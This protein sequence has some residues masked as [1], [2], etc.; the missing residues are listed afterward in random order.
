MGRVFVRVLILCLIF[1]GA[2]L[3]VMVP[4]GGMAF[5]L[6]GDPGQPGVS[7]PSALVPIIL[8]GVV[9]YFVIIGFSL[10]LG[11]MIP[12]AA[13]GHVVSVREALTL[14]KGHAWRIFWSMIMIAIP[15]VVLGMLFQATMMAGATAGDIGAG[16]VPVGI[17]TLVVDLF[18][19]IVLIAANA[20]WYEKLRLR[21]AGPDTGSGPAFEFESAAAPGT[22]L[23]PRAGSGVGPYADLPED[24]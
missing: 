2:V 24:K 8:A 14:T 5:S 10:R 12:G 17:L 18:T 16:A 7:N 4:L 9:L 22:A 23:D 3:V 1:F 13:V 20:V 21:M 6:L 19:W 15:T 11:V